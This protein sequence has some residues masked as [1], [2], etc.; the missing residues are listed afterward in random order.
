MTNESLR[1]GRWTR[2]LFASNRVRVLRT[3]LLLIASATLFWGSQAAAQGNQVI[4]LHL[5]AFGINQL[6]SLNPSLVYRPIDDVGVRPGGDAWGMGGAHLARATGAGAIAWNPAG[7]S[8]ADATELYA[9]GYSVTSSGEASGYP[10]ALEIPGSGSIF[11]TSYRQNLKGG[12]K[13]GMLAAAAPLWSSGES[14]LVGGLSWR[15]YSNVSYPEETVNDFIFSEL[16]GFPVVISLDRA[17]RGAVEAVGPSLAFRFGSAF[18]VGANLN[19]LTGRLR[20]STEQRVA[21][22][23]QLAPGIQRISTKYEGFVPDLGIRF[24]PANLAMPIAL[25][26][27][28][29]PA[30]TL[31]IRGGDFY[32]QSLSAP[33][34]PQVFIDGKLVG[35]D[36]KVPTS[37]ALG[38]EVRPFNRLAVAVDWNSHKWSET[39]VSYLD[40]AQNA[41]FGKPVLPLRDVSSIH[42]GAEYMLLRR[43]WGDVPIRGGFHTAPQSF[44]YLDSTDVSSLDGD[45][46]YEGSKQVEGNAWTMGASLVT[47]NVSFDLA[48]DTASYDLNKLYFDSPRGSFSNPE[49]ILVDLKRTVRT[50]RF[51]TTFRFGGPRQP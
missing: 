12:M 37:M 28:L 40:D 1:V 6:I 49:G 24:A 33:G 27:R 7:L 23:A 16:G 46:L 4:E 51:S 13:P 22:G 32:S 41:Q 29:S 21:A 47:G 43:S 14:R 20:A 36:M 3:A 18:S 9:D 17:E 15:R 38:A 26:A 48:V 10:T 31:K 2:G 50:L 11:S 39:E 34:Q 30:Y 5:G 25:A 19:Y 8:A 35:Y 42:I 44:S 45:A